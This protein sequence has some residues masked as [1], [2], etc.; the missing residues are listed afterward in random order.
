MYQLNFP[1]TIKPSQNRNHKK[2]DCYYMFL[3][4]KA[5]SK[6]WLTFSVLTLIGLTA[7]EET[8]TVG[9]DFIQESSIQVDTVRID[10]IDLV[11]IDP[12]LGQLTY[13]ALGSFEDPLFGELSSTLYFKPSINAS[14]TDTVLDYMRFEMRLHLMEDEIYGDTS[15][16]AE[17]DVYR[18]QQSWHGPSF[19]QSTD[20]DL[21]LERIGG[22][23]DAEID[24]N[25]NVHIALGGSWDSFYR[26]IFNIDDDSIRLTRYAEEDFGLAI[27]PKNTANRIRFATM[28]TSRLL[29]IGQEDTSSYGVQDW[30][31]NIE[32][33]GVDPIPNRLMLH[34]TFE[35]VLKIDLN[36]LGNQLPNTNFVRA[37]L[38]LEEDTTR[39][40]TSLS[41]H[42]QRLNV[43]GF[44]MSEGDFIDLAYQFGFSDQNIINGYP[45]KGR[46]R[47]DITQLLNDQIYNNNPIKD[48][49]IYP[50]VN[51]GYIGS[52]IL[53]SKDTPP[54]KRPRLIIYSIQSEEE[55]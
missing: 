22:F 28:S 36:S 35:Q 17:F 55:K 1:I 25:G 19:R 2:E 42:E 32:R 13:S 44:R 4:N 21:G 20:I 50:Y 43:P 8:N 18:I 26:E 5:T 52:N 16:T 49:Y 53:Y 14:S 27:V 51:A 46:F 33:T 15:S 34:N 11:E 7:C 47:F 30:A 45:A 54:E 48:S 9:V 3:T 38:V 41:E 40:K 6:R 12:Y 37:E 24:T 10:Q 31:Y 23:S 39:A 29:V